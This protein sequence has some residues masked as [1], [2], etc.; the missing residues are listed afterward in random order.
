MPKLKTQKCDFLVTFKHLNPELRKTPPGGILCTKMNFLELNGQHKLFGPET[1]IQVGRRNFWM[2]AS[3][4]PGLHVR[5]RYGHA[6]YK[7]VQHWITLGITPRII[8]IILH[9]LTFCKASIKN[10]FLQNCNDF[11]K[12]RDNRI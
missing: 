10:S 12:F 7:H 5:N 2:P 1:R 9:L 8:I 6:I 3:Y 11:V 4:N